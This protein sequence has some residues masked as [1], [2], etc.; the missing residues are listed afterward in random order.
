LAQLKIC[1]IVAGENDSSGGLDSVTDISQR[2]APERF[3][4]GTL[5]IVA[6]V[7]S[8]LQGV[9]SHCNVQK[10]R[11]NSASHELRQ[12]QFVNCNEL[13]ATLKWDPLIRFH[14]STR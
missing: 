5:R 13:G 12:E 6:G 9:T 14:H 4:R 11:A 2:S 3:V 10:T 8:Q 1:G 7:S